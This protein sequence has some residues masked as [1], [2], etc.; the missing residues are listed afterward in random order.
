MNYQN[1]MK[2]WESFEFIDEYFLE[3]VELE[4]IT[5][6]KAKRAMK[7][8]IIFVSVIMIIYRLIKPKKRKA[9]DMKF[10]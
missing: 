9:F 3:E 10:M 7:Y 5:R 8:G 4:S 1:A 2:L 6:A